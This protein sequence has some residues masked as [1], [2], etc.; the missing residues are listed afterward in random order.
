M[1]IGL[2]ID[3][4][5][6]RPDGVQ[7]YVLTIGAWLSGQGHEVHYLT[8]Q[9]VRTDLPKLHSLSRNVNVRFNGNGLSIPLPAS[10][11]RIAALLAEERFDVLHVQMP[12]SPM[13][14]ARIVNAAPATTVVMGTFHILPYSRLVRSATRLLGLALGRSLKRFD[15]VFAVSTAARDFAERSFGLTG[16]DVLPNVVDAGRF[17][18]AAKRGQT[19]VTADA[20]AGPAA[21]ARLLFLGRLVPR[22]GCMTFLQA[23]AELHADAGFGRPLKV[24]VAGKGP[25]AGEL[26]AQARSLGIADITNFTGFIAEEDK[27]LLLAGATIAAYPSSGGESF[28]IVLVEA[29]AASTARTGPVVLAARNPGYATV[30]EPQPGQLFEPLDH[31][32]LAQ[33]MRHFLGDTQAADAARRW[34]EMYVRQFDVATVGRRLVAAYSSHLRKRSES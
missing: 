31:H 25:L 8:G 1:K 3:D 19:G 7:Q 29:M 20:A 30:M 10:R 6:D 11:R 16:V 33:L 21:E 12:Y 32:G 24:I 28:G 14:A 2:V 9:T 23:V 17:A 26:K 13:L 5:L 22:K 4:S 15:Q 27:P 34:Q 18:A